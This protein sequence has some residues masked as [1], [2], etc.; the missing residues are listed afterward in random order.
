MNI[1][2]QI[3]P[4]YLNITLIECVYII[5]FCIYLFVNPFPDYLLHII[6][7][8]VSGLI[9]ITLTVRKKMNAARSDMAKPAKTEQMNND[10]EEVQESN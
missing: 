3:K 1:W 6:G 2:K 4:K 5:L 9:M 8:Y 7:L 10:Q